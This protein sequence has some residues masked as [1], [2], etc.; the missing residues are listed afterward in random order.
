ML[1]PLVR[2]LF[3][4]SFHRTLHTSSPALPFRIATQLQAEPPKKRQKIDPSVLKERADRKRNRIVKGIKK[5]NTVEPK[6]KPIDEYRVRRQIRLEADERTRDP[7]ELSFD[8]SERRIV[9]QKAWSRFR[10]AILFSER[11]KIERIQLSQALA[12][13]ELRLVSESLYR[14]AIGVDERLLMA[15][16]PDEEEGERT[17]LALTF[18]REGPS[19]TPPVEQYESPDGEYQDTSRQW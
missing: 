6:P 4:F 18:E 19:E 8:E 14:A 10:R 9:L 3:A 7:V 5:L 2:P 13:K 17:P 1:S 16:K 12:L 15:E 11:T